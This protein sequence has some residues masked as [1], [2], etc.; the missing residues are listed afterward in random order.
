MASLPLL[1]CLLHEDTQIIRFS[2]DFLRQPEEHT[3]PFFVYPEH[4]DLDD[5]G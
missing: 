1:A 5:A 3:L 2:G 4:I